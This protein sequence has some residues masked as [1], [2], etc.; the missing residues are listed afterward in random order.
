MLSYECPLK[1]RPPG[2]TSR[3]CV[4]DFEF[5]CLSF[6]LFVS[7][8]RTLALSLSLSLSLYVSLSLS[9][10]LSLSLCLSLTLS[11][12]H[13]LSLV[14]VPFEPSPAGRELATL[15]VSGFGFRSHDICDYI[16]V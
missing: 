8:T 9:L 4:C 7:P 2:E 10:T 5:Y 13:H 15:Q 1:R 6:S 12:T 14:G 16:N 3:D 11:L